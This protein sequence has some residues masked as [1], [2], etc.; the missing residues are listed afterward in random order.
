MAFSVRGAAAELPRARS[1]A[2]RCRLRSLASTS[3]RSRLSCALSAS[4]ET[5]CALRFRPWSSLDISSSCRCRMA[6]CSLASAASSRTTASSSRTASDLSSRK[7]RSS[8]KEASCLWRASLSSRPASR[9]LSSRRALC[10]AFSSCTADSRAAR[11][12][13]AS[14]TCSLLIRAEASSKSSCISSLC[15]AALLVSCLDSQRASLRTRSSAALS[16]LRIVSAR[17][18]TSFTAPLRAASALADE[19]ASCVS[20]ALRSS[21][22]SCLARSSCS[23]FRCRKASRHRTRFASALRVCSCCAATHEAAA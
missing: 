11:S 15:L 8:S 4:W 7:L 6:H 22:S 13:S 12:S 19:V 16:L 20:A 17:R 23:T 21:W 1:M 18:C 3:A 10:E 5:A 2:D 9:T 14:T